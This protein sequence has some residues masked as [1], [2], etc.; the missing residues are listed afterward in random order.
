[1]IMSNRSM[2]ITSPVLSIMDRK[3][4]VALQ[5]PLDKCGNSMSANITMLPSGTYFYKLAGEDNEGNP[6]SHIVRRKISIPAGADRY[7]L[8]G[9]GPESEEVIS[10]Q[11][12]TL[13]FELRSTNSFGSVNFSFAIAEDI[14]PR[15][16]EPQRAVL[17]YGKVT[18]V[19]VTIRPTMS[20]QQVTL[21]AT[22]D[23][24]TIVSAKKTL[25]LIQ[26]VSVNTAMSSLCL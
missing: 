8:T 22:S 3:G 7:S 6:F 19:N 15:L 24:S 18:K 21:I 16:V 14:S 9:L 5:T 11:V 12:V 20:P 25:E 10:G 2:E 23:C 13:T 26:P 1:M 4:D 17:S